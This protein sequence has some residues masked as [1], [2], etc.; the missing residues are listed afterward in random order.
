MMRNRQIY[1][2]FICLEFKQT[3][4][5]LKE[6]ENIDWRVVENKAIGF[7]LR[8]VHDVFNQKKH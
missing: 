7:Q 2:L 5:F 6:T 1:A 4:A 3:H 8:K